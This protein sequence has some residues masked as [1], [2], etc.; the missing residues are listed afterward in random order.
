MTVGIQT[1]GTT[2]PNFSKLN[3]EYWQ[4]GDTEIRIGGSAMD[5]DSDTNESFRKYEI[6]FREGYYYTIEGKNLEF[7]KKSIVAN[8]FPEFEYDDLFLVSST[9]KK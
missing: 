3:V 1:S 7:L 5:K 4:I 8:F 6:K 2:H 9:V